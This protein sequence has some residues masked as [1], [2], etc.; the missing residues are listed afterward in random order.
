MPAA[1]GRT[2]DT[3]DTKDLKRIFEGVILMDGKKVNSWSGQRTNL[4][5]GGCIEGSRP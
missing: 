4:E 2:Q 3:K 5:H 1:P